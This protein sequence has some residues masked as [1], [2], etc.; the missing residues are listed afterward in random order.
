MKA[1]AFSN[2]VIEDEDGEK[3]MKW[4]QPFP[5]EVPQF[6]MDGG[7][8]AYS[9]VND[10]LASGQA[11]KDSKDPSVPS[12]LPAFPHS[13]TYKKSSSSRKRGNPASEEGAQSEKRP[14]SNVVK[15]A[16]QSLA[17]LEDSADEVAIT[18]QQS[19]TQTVA[20]K[21]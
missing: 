8:E 3:I 17:R 5:F 13:H 4:N 20:D 9:D 7:S 18:S 15:S 21:V 1:F 14:K 6:P 16:R 10:I 19:K 2:E 12:H 11:S